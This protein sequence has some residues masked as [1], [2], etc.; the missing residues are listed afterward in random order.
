[1][2][3]IYGEQ[4]L[5]ARAACALLEPMQQPATTKTEPGSGVL[6]TDFSGAP[7]FH[8]RPM[9]LIAFGLVLGIYLGDGF[10]G[11]RV[12]LAAGALAL[13]ALGALFAK[14]PVWALFLLFFAAGFL[15]VSIAAPVP[16]KA[17]VGTLSGTVCEEPAARGGGQWRVTLE[18]AALDGEP[19]P[20]RVR[21]Y[22][23]FAETPAY[24]Q[25]VSL[26]AS[27]SPSSGEY[28]M[29]DRYYGVSAAAFGKSAAAV[30]ARTPPDLY[31]RLLELRRSVGNRI[32]TLFPDAP[33]VAKGMLLGDVS[34]IDED[35]LTAFRNTGIAHLLAVSGLHVSLLA[36]AFSLLFRR[37]A[38]VRFGATGVFLALYAA[39]TA[40]SP[41]VVRSSIMFLL[42]MLAFPLRRR[43][44]TVSSLSAACALLLLWNPYA[45]WNAGFQLSFVAVLSMVLLAPPLQKPLEP[46]GKTASGLVAASA[47]VVIGTFPTTCLFFGQA[48]FLSLVTNLFVLPLSGVF[49]VPA[50]FGTMLSYLWFPLGNAVCAVG[51]PV[52]DV[53]LAVASYGGT[54]AVSVSAPPT[55]AYLLGLFALFLAS[56]LCL[57][58]GRRRAVY[59][60]SAFALAGTLWA[61][62]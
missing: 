12:W 16:A 31:G 59:A 13:A 14:K 46:L 33:A 53:V 56:P 48:Q 45:L 58:S 37:N 10:F 23:A 61:A 39:L 11:A 6:R 60:L 9:F 17:G 26:T 55:A 62:L 7:L 24:G 27:V 20:G 8:A 22:A 54:L 43:L 5:T 29:Y 41:P 1:M 49:L 4:A 28:K 36:A 51:R 52:L 25:T 3:K 57:R 2:P 35:T 42:A 40:F 50:F 32:E 34:E 30:L 15:R 44:D 21:L 18:N 19:V 38:W 47:A